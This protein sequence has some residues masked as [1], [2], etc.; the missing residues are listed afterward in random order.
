M[1]KTSIANSNQQPERRKKMKNLKYIALLA[2]GFMAAC[3]P[4]LDRSIV[5]SPGAAPVVQIPEFQSFTID[6][7][8]QI[9]LVENHKLPSVSYQLSVDW[10]VIIEG[11]KAGAAEMAG[12]IV[13]KGTASKSK[14]EIDE[15][16]DFIGASFGTSSSGMFGRSLTKHSGELL[17]LMSDILMNPTFPEEELEK[18]KTQTLSGLVSANTDPNAMMSNVKGIT[19]YGMDHPYGEIVTEQTVENISRQDLVDFYNA[20]WKPNHSYLVVVGDI[21]KEEAKANAQKYF[22]NWEKGDMPNPSFEAHKN[23][24]GNNVVFVPLKDAVQSTIHVTYPVDYKRGAEDAM[25]ASVMNTILGG[26]V[27]SGRLMQNLREDKGYTYGSGSNLSSDRVVGVFTASASVRNEVTDSSVTE[28]LYELDRMITEPVNDSILNFVKNSMAGGFAR[29]LE[30]SRS[31]ARFALNTFRYNLPQDYYNNY[32]QRLEAVTAADIS[33][34]AKKYIKPGNANIIVVGNKDEA[35]KLT[36]FSADGKVIMLDQYGNEWKDMVPA[37]DGV[38]AVS[39]IEDYA[40]AIGGRENV[41]AIKTLQQLGTMNMMGMDIAID[42]KLEVGEK[43][44]MKMGEAP[45][46]MYEVVC[47][48]K[49]VSMKQMGQSIPTEPSMVE[50]FI[51]QSYPFPELEY[52]KLGYT[53]TLDGVIEMDGEEVYVMTVTDK[54]GMPKTE[55]YSVASGLKVKEEQTQEVPGMGEMTSMTMYKK[56]MEQDGIKFASQMSQIEG[57]QQ[58]EISVSEV[59]INPKFK[60]TEF[61]VN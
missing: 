9:I 24:K 49:E 32:L 34:A 55:Y 20:Y 39:V 15:A 6:N 48:G 26:G 44:S 22:G 42:T 59:K 18:A 23:P 52:E 51:S 31:V 12:D 8:L 60:K 13:R 30:S 3:S 10:D 41:A 21:T 54:E 29:S 43:F 37:P 14:A 27:F 38:T 28:I 33:A 36:K 40:E 61:K 58:M 7:G 53:L 47:D 1:M 57:P 35:E 25:A 11:D 50:E 2:I 4:K 17:S 16:M 56:Y 46:V 45:M 19:N 5:P